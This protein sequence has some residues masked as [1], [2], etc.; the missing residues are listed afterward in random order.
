VNVGYKGYDVAGITPLFP[1]G[2]GLSYTTFGYSRLGVHAP[3]Q[4]PE[5]SRLSAR[6][7]G[8]ACR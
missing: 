7:A 6:L 3:N 4:G 2:Y 8:I 5:R 1:F